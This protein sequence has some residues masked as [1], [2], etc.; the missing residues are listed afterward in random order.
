M[1]D[2][3]AAY[4]YD[5][6]TKMIVHVW[7]HYQRIGKTNDIEQQDCTTEMV[8][9]QKQQMK[10]GEPWAFILDLITDRNIDNLGCVHAPLLDT[11]MSYL[12]ANDAVD[13][14]QLIPKPYLKLSVIS[15]DAVF[16]ESKMLG[17]SSTKDHYTFDSDGIKE[18]ELTLEACDFSDTKCKR[19]KKDK[20]HKGLNKK[21]RVYVTHGRLDRKN[22]IYDLTDGECIIKWLL[23]DQSITDAQIYAGDTHKEFVKSSHLCSNTINVECT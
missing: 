18:L 19:G 23:P 16:I 21:V 15:P 2:K 20:K 12:C 17:S 1:T 6:Q 13:P 22:G 3:C 5:K 7:R 9:A 11:S 4:F 14:P 10:D 8:E